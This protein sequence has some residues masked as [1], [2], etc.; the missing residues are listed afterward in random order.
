MAARSGIPRRSLRPSRCTVPTG[1]AAVAGGLAAALLVASPAG[2]HTGLPAGGAV[3]GLWHPVHGI[4][5]LLAMVAVG[6]IAA[7]VPD[8]RIAWLTPAGFLAGMVVGGA[9]GLAGLGLPAV[10]LAIAGSVVVLGALVVALATD[11]SRLRAGLWLPVVA[12]I[13]G[14]AHGHA[15][16][17]ELPTGAIPAAYLL[18]FLAATTALHLAGAAAGLGL[19]R[20]KV[21]QVVAGAAVSAAGVL[22]LTGA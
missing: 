17:A 8:R 3:D 19:R 20:V 13:F 22:L 18:G 10:E 11:A 5:H 12:A 21:A 9:A 7:A 4:D 15:H 6:V 2:A 14:A 16:G 1:V